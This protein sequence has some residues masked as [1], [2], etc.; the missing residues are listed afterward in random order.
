MTETVDVAIIG[1]GPAGM[2]AAVELQR[3]GLRVVVLDERAGPGG[4]V[5]A[6]GLDGPFSASQLL[7]RDYARGA[8]STKAYAATGVSTRYGCGI[9]RID[10]EI[11]SYLQAGSL[12]RLSAARLLVATGAIERPMPFPGWELPGVMGAGAF[13]LLMKQ[14]GVVPAGDYVLC[15]TGPLVL[16]MAC[17]LLSLG[18]RPAAILDTNAT[19]SPFGTGFSHLGALARN[20]G[21]VAKGLTYLSRIRLAGIPVVGGVVALAAAGAGSVERLDYT[22]RSGRTGS[23]A[24]GL[25][26]C[27]EGV[28]PNTQMTL[29]LGCGHRWDAAQGCVVPVIDED[30]RSSRAGTFVAGDAAG[31]LG[32]AAAPHS[33][34]VAAIRIAQDLG[35]ITPADA[36]RLARAARD[37]LARERTFRAFL[38]RA[39]R[40]GIA[41]EAPL[42]DATVICRCENVT[43]GTLRQAVRDGARGPAQAKVF[44]RSG[45]GLCQGRICG[46]AVNRILADETGQSR[47]DIGTYHVRFPLKPLSLTELAAGPE[48]HGG[49]A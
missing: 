42:A 15:G 39:Y 24:A 12:R 27:H 29:A 30:G 14:S 2:A 16:L 26:L 31:I 48:P 18:S 38:D 28:V 13:Q 47:D 3:L 36:G 23:I 22:Q 41:A 45:M 8:R 11:V 21:S 33:G 5:N 4:N 7:G 44:T 17:Q 20:A 1:A 49:D 32:A 19:R 35:R 25:V 10:G 9:S 37:G 40:P 43:A 46:S 6:A 34:R